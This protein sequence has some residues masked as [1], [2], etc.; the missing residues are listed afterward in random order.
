MGQIYFT[1]LS[2]PDHNFT[3]EGSY[4]DSYHEALIVWDELREKALN[5]KFVAVDITV[6]RNYMRVIDG[7]P[8]DREVDAH[9]EQAAILSL[10]TPREISL[11][12]ATLEGTLAR[13]L[14]T[15]NNDEP[16]QRH[17][18]PGLPVPM[19]ICYECDDYVVK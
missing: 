7:K 16:E 6:A 15:Q 9:K 18:L 13:E 2:S 5:G 1:G 3:N 4:H 10:R 17:K 8:I 19:L 12:L 11:V 14:E